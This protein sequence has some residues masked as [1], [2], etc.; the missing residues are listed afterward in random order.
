VRGWGRARPRRTSTHDPARLLAPGRWLQG[1][2]ARKESEE[3]IRLFRGGE[4]KVDLR[5][6]IKK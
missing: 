2:G 5:F 4:D 6:K 1:T 3:K